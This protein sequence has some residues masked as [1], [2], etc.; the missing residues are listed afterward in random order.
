MQQLPSEI[1]P[2]VGRLFLRFAR[3]AHTAGQ[4]RFGSKA[5]CERIRWHM[6]IEQGVRTFKLNNNW[7]ARLA[8]W[9]MHQDPALRGMFE[10]RIS[11][12][13]RAYP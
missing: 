11:R 9:A 1:P 10:T 2:E 5:I 6:R 13:E 12:D 3:E 7:T 4:T 8:R